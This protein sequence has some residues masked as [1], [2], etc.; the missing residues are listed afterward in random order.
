M[1]RVNRAELL[2]KKNY[3]WWAIICIRSRPNQHLT[4][5]RNV[6]SF[7]FSFLVQAQTQTG[8]FHIRVHEICS[9]LFYSV[10]MRWLFLLFMPFWLDSLGTWFMQNGSSASSFWKWMP[11]SRFENFPQWW[12]HFK[13]TAKVNTSWSSLQR[14]NLLI[15]GYFLMIHGYLAKNKTN[16]I[17]NNW[18][19]SQPLNF[20]IGSFHDL[21]NEYIESFLSGKLWLRTSTQHVH[22]K[23]Q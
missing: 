20:N 4:G 8:S 18:K 12:K 3:D 23:K 15:N 7:T 16:H 13:H 10:L 22:G 9:P 11:Y 17:I 6:R 21:S 19:L 14:E 2:I 5:R 1:T